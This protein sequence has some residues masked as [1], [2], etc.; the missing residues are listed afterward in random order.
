M[1]IKFVTDRQNSR[2]G[3]N[4]S[5]ISR[6]I[7]FVFW[8]KSVWLKC[9]HPAI[10]PFFRLLPSCSV[11]CISLYFRSLFLF[12]CFHL[13]SAVILLFLS[14]FA[15]SYLLYC[16]HFPLLFPYRCSFLTFVPSFTLL[17]PTPPHPTPHF[18]KLAR[19]VFSI[20]S[21]FS[22]F[23]CSLILSRIRILILKNP[24]LFVLYGVLNT[25]VCEETFRA[26]SGTLQS[27]ANTGGRRQCTFIIEQWQGYVVHLQFTHFNLGD[28]SDNCQNT[29]LEVGTQ[30]RLCSHCWLCGV[31]YRWVQWGS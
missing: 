2:T 27:P 8:N 3:F 25:P 9:K 17:P 12:L 24:R 1:R 20:P 10:L 15:I 29:Y 11:T 16:S 28:G 14:R 19:I 13:N 18:F 23:L 22:P 30:W 31:L 21:T 26:A 6:K 7:C 4:A 5:W